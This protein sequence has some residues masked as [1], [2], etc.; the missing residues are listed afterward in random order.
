[1]LLQNFEAILRAAAEGLA[2]IPAETLSERP[3]PDRWSGKEVLGHLIDSA[4]NNHQR[5]L[6]GATQ[7]HLRFVGYD[8]NEWVRRNAYQQ[9]P[10]EEVVATFFTVQ[11][12][13][14]AVIA[15]LP[16]D[17]LNRQTSEHDFHRMAMRKVAAGTPSSLG[18]LIEDYLYH[19]VHHLRQII[20]G[21]T[22]EWY[23]GYGR[24]VEH[25]PNA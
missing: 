7:E 12:H 14:A 19:L 9:R 1:M 8:Q 2:Q 5:F 21:F 24:T 20:P 13:L 4:Y 6:R 16:E 18:F 15:T 22:A 17:R 3:G 10:A 25:R 11:H 23:S